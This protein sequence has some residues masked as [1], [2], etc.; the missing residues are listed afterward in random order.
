M[1]P[2][3]NV[4]TLELPP[5][6]KHQKLP[7]TKFT[8]WGLTTNVNNIFNTYG[9]MSFTAPGVFPDN[10]NRAGFTS[11]MMAS[12][13]NASFGTIGIPARSFFATLTYNF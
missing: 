3:Q 4:L 7:N 6:F 13:P 12:N 5:H 10:L 9:V 1:L 2:L 11:D 8:I